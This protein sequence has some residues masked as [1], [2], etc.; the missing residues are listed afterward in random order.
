MYPSLRVARQTTGCVCAVRGGF[1]T[2]G[3]Q[4]ARPLS[5]S[6]Q[7][8]NTPLPTESSEITTLSNPRIMPPS[9]GWCVRSCVVVRLLRYLHSVSGG[10]ILVGGGQWWPP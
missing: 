8:P 6:D 1:V 2:V 5:A 3:G 10:C 7:P 9:V 4:C